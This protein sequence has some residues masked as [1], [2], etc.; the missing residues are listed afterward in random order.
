MQDD[1]DS[2]ELLSRFQDTLDTL[3]HC[4]LEEHVPVKLTTSHPVVEDGG[5]TVWNVGTSVDEKGGHS[6]SVIKFHKDRPG[7]TGTMMIEDAQVSLQF[8]CLVFSD[9]LP[10][11]SLSN[12]CNLYV[13]AFV[14]LFGFPSLPS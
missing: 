9:L 14:S 6:Y 1:F 4:E 10:S 8:F 3:A 7:V 2:N 5:D 12:S 11:L 13:C